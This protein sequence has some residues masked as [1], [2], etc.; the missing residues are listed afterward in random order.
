[1]LDLGGFLFTRATAQTAF[2]RA[3]NPVDITACNFSA[4]KLDSDYKEMQINRKISA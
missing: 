3:V 1:M 2:V 4:F